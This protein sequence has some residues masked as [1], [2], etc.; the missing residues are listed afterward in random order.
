M[1]NINNLKYWNNFYKKKK[2]KITPTNFS[3]FCITFL[4]KDDVLFDLG[5][6]N[7]RDV[8]FFEKK[9]INVFGIDKSAA[10]INSIKLKKLRKGNLLV[11]DFS[12]INLENI[13]NDY[14]SI[15]MRFSLH[16]ITSLQEKNFFK[17]VLKYKKIKFMFIET[18]TVNDELYKIGKKVGNNEY[19]ASHY[20]RFIVPKLIK[21]EIKKKFRIIYFKVAKGFAKYKKEDPKVLRI[22][23]LKC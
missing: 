5:C 12:K 7:G 6:G 10:G 11:G 17:K 21:N 4:K 13:T 9:G 18:R 22:V 2:H 15:Y 8:L 14:F 23:A 1:I 19:I 3:K 16:A 20:R